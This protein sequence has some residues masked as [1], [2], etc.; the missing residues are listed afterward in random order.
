[1]VPTEGMGGGGGGI[2]WRVMSGPGG[3]IGVRSRK[4]LAVSSPGSPLVR[5]RSPFCVSLCTFLYFCTLRHKQGDSQL[6]GLRWLVSFSLCQVT[7]CVCNVC[8]DIRKCG[9]CCVAVFVRVHACTRVRSRVMSEQTV[10]ENYWKL[11]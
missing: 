9:M 1:M 11:E 10:L 8:R 5:V 7:L 4:K 2:G 3:G 6:G